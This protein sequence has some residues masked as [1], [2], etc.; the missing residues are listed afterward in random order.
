MLSPVANNSRVDGQPEFTKLEL[1]FLQVER[2]VNI[3]CSIRIHR[4]A[5]VKFWDDLNIVEQRLQNNM[6]IVL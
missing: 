3:W 1:E 6:I 4:A 5:S 2:F